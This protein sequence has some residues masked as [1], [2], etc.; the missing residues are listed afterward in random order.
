MPPLYF[1]SSRVSSYK[2][3]LC[4]VLWADCY[5]SVSCH[6]WQ[7]VWGRDYILFT[8]LFQCAAQT[9]RAEGAQERSSACR[10]FLSQRVF[11][12]HELICYLHARGGLTLATMMTSFIT[13]NKHL[14]RV[15]AGTPGPASW[16]THFWGWGHLP[17]VLNFPL[18]G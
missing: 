2:Q 6:R 3:T 10:S 15:S 13:V 1:P 5:L 14:T 11:S 18:L 9:W 8:S 12:N 4:T 7:A 16:S 17:T